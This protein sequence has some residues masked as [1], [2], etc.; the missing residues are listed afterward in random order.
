MF[1]TVVRAGLCASLGVIFATA[2]LAHAPSP[3]T[4]AADKAQ[5][6]AAKDPLAARFGGPF[7]LVASDE[8]T[9][10]DKTYTGSFRL[11]YFGY[12]SC[13]DI[14]PVDLTTLGAAMDLLGD[15]GKVVQPLFITVDPARD[16]TAHL[17]RFIKSFHPRILALTGSEADIAA[18]A[19]A[20]KVHRVKVIADPTHPDDYLV[21]HGSLTYLM[22]RDGRFLTLIPRGAT[23]EKI[24]SIVRKYITSP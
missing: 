20:Y 4:Q 13:P 18:V 9:V 8:T 24:A 7:S 17:A 12:T 3:E 23:P 1:T 10:T 19:K 2:T 22:G 16:T 11:V 6:E 21:D 5:I 15:D 14:C